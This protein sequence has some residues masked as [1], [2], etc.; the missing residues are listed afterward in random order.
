MDV[1][2][3]SVAA[4]LLAVLLA[5]PAAAARGGEYRTEV[6][7]ILASNSDQGF[8]PRLT[9]LRPDLLALNYMSFQ[10][11]DQAGLGLARDQEGRVTV[12]GGRTMR[13]V[14]RGMEGGKI[15]MD[16][17]VT[18]GKVSLVKTHIRIANH[19][20]VII[21]GPPYQAGFL[22]LAVSVHF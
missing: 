4:V 18:Q 14:P 17:E 5:V 15:G 2:A 20:T 8:D 22:L 3:V 1:R 13:V 6:R 12:P 7:V 19:G 9:D 16:V 21:G 11:L 10:L